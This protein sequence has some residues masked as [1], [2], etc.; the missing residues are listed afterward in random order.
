MHSRRSN[1]LIEL[2]K[3]DSIRVSAP[4]DCGKVIITVCDAKQGYYKHETEEVIVPV[5]GEQHCPHCGMKLE[6]ATLCDPLGSTPE[7]SQFTY[8]SAPMAVKHE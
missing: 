7:F 6:I 5:I 3:F 1:N 2:S 4:C 8:D